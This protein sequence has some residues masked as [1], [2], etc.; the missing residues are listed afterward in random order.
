MA[1]NREEPLVF[2]LNGGEIARDLWG[3]AD[4]D[5][6]YM[7][8]EEMQD[9][10]PLVQGPVDRR[11]GSEFIAAA[12][13]ETAPVA[14]LD[15]EFAKTQTYV[16]EAGD[17][18][19]RFYRNRALVASGGPP[20]PV[21]LATPYLAADVASLHYAQSFDVLYIAN[22]NYAPRALSRTSDT[23][24]SLDKLVLVDG[25]YLPINADQAMT[26]VLTGGPPWTAGSSLTMTAAGHNPFQA[27]HVGSIWRLQAG[28]TD[29]VWVTVTGFTNDQNV[30]VTAEVDV[31]A[32]LQGATTSEWR[33]GLWSDVRG[34]PATVT[35]HEE[36][37][38]FGG[39]DSYPWDIE[40]SASGLFL[41]FSPTTGDGDAI[42]KILA[43]QGANAVQWLLS[44]EFLFAGTNAAAM[45]VGPAGTESALTPL[46]C[47]YKRIVGT[48]A[49]PVQARLCDSYVI[50][51]NR[52][53]L[54]LTG[55]R[56]SR[57]PALAADLDVT[58]RCEHITGPGIVRLGWQ[59]APHNLLWALR[60][61]GVLV[62]FTINLAERVIGAA[63]HI[64]GGTDAFVESFAIIPGAAQDELWL[65]VRRTINGATRRY[66][67]V[68]ADFPTET[69]DAAD[70]W[71][72]DS[73]L[74][75]DGAP[76]TVLTGFDHLE[77]ESLTV[78]ADGGPVG[79]AVVVGGQITLTAAASKVV[80][81]LRINGRL[82]PTSAAPQINRDFGLLKRR[83][84]TR[85][86]YQLQRSIGF[87]HGRD[88]DHLENISL[89]PS[90]IA[91]QAPALYS[92][93]IEKTFEGGWSRTSDLQ[94]VVDQPGP[95]KL[96][97]LQRDMEF[98]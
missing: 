2:S 75:Y 18:V 12:E 33:E 60:S 96:S 55:F 69:T 44:G 56:N 76:A 26:L 14:L 97:G 8:A 88:D 82:R 7:S 39:S 68:L 25:P 62:S 78:W 29:Y 59:K 80:A 67:E 40:A 21:V 89:D 66:I 3:R 15:F 72:S 73:A 28:T 24:W 17:Q 85:I 79:V 48:S 31:P 42:Q 30:T 90:P 13:D 32:S 19:F 47:P 9:L 6:F 46:N 50:Y 34:W 98:E 95:W 43:G 23:S 94:I 11:P 63:R 81:G 1:G 58:L 54:R 10:V 4:Q 64:I 84:T 91:G 71:Y 70:M 83:R 5:F 92:G 37:L 16:I 87:K 65:L 53:G 49:G 61:D 57:D 45:R 93:V 74:M 51:V 22:V 77:G 27:A 36:R 41:T 20:V 52:Y 38:T 35:F 86:R